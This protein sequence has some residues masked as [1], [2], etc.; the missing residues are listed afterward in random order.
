MADDDDDIRLAL[1]LLLI[2]NSYRVI[3]AANAQEI[4][5]QADREKHNLVLLDMNFSRDTTSG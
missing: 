2:T 5:S 3:H 4:G 1:E